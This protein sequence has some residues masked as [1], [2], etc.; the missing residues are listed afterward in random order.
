MMSHEHFFVITRSFYS[1]KVKPQA[2]VT[3]EIQKFKFSM[4][5]GRRIH[6]SNVTNLRPCQLKANFTKTNLVVTTALEVG[7]LVGA[8][9]KMLKN[10]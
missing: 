4:Y 5:L 3:F 10:F 2:F 1:K 7:F 8:G 6:N 9:V